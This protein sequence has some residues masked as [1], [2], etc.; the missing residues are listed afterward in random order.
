MQVRVSLSAF[1]WKFLENWTFL[2]DR[3]LDIMLKGRRK[4]CR[5]TH[6]RPGIDEFQE[7]CPGL[8]DL[9]SPFSNGG[10]VCMLIVNQLITDPV[11][12]GNLLCANIVCVATKLSKA[13]LQHLKI[14]IIIIMDSY[15]A[16]MSVIQCYSWR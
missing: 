13:L 8:V 3:L 15:I 16:L 14:I 5:C 6:P 7:I 2:N 10:S 12:T 1:R 11:D 4:V 9:V